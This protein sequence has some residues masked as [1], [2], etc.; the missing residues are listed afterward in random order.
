MFKY[1]PL[2]FL[3][4]GTKNKAYSKKSVVNTFPGHIKKPVFQ[5]KFSVSYGSFSIPY[6]CLIAHVWFVVRTTMSQ[7]ASILVSRIFK[8]VS[9]PQSFY[10]T[11]HSKEKRRENS[12]FIQ[13]N[14]VFCTIKMFFYLLNGE[15]E[16]VDKTSFK[17]FKLVS[18]CSLLEY[19]ALT[20]LNLSKTS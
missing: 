19:F 7:S 9:S 18:H 13:V 17:C 1:L 3:H 15:E 20:L 14:F 2:V 12:F 10:T 8:E 16:V 5:N 4:N 6:V 11:F